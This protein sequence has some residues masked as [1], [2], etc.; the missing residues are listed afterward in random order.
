MADRLGLETVLSPAAMNPYFYPYGPYY[1][2]QQRPRFDPGAEFRDNIFAR[3]YE[4]YPNY[5]LMPQYPAPPPYPYGHYH[6]PGPFFQNQYLVPPQQY[7]APAPAVP[8]PVLRDHAA[9]HYTMPVHQPPSHHI[10]VPEPT[11]VH[12]ID[13][14][15]VPDP[16]QEPGALPESLLWNP[17]ADGNWSR[18]YTK[19]EVDQSKSLMEHWAN[20]SGSGDRR[21]KVDATQ[22]Q[23][24][25]RTRRKCLGIMQCEAEP[26]QCDVITRPQT[27]KDSRLRQLAALVPVKARE[28]FVRKSHQLLDCDTPAMLLK[29]V[30]QLT[31]SFPHTERFF[32]WWMRKEV[33]MMLFP[34]MTTMHPDLWNVMPDSTNA[35]EAMHQRFYL[36][37]KCGGNH[38]ILTG[39][40]H[41]Y[42]FLDHC[43]RQSIATRTGQDIR[44]GP[45]QRWKRKTKI[46][47]LSK[48]QGAIEFSKL[49]AKSRL[50]PAKRY[51]NDGR[52]PVKAKRLLQ[53]KL[54]QRSKK[55]KSNRQDT[56]T[57]SNSGR[58]Q[59]NDVPPSSVVV[60]GAQ[61]YVW[62]DNSCWHDTS[63]QVFCVVLNHDWLVFSQ[64]LH[65]ISDANPRWI[66][67]WIYRW[68]KNV[69]HDAELAPV[70]YFESWRLLYQRCTGSSESS[71]QP[72]AKIFAEPKIDPTLTLFC[73][74]DNLHEF[75]G[76]MQKWFT[77][78]TNV[79]QFKPSHCWHVRQG[80]KLCK[81]TCEECQCY[82][83][84]PVILII[85]MMYDSNDQQPS[86]PWKVPLWLK[87]W[88]SAKGTPLSYELRARI[89]SNTGHFKVRYR[90]S[91]IEEQGL[92]EYDGV[93]HGGRPISLRNATLASHLAGPDSGLKDL[94]KGYYTCTVI[95]QVLGRLSTVHQFH[96]DQ[97]AALKLFHNVE[98]STDTLSVL[99]RLS[100]VD[101]AY[102]ICPDKDRDWLAYPKQSKMID[103]RQVKFKRKSGN[104][105]SSVTKKP[106]IE[107]SDHR[108]PADV[109]DLTSDVEGRSLDSDLE[110]KDWENDS[111]WAGIKSQD[112]QTTDLP[113]FILGYSP[114]RDQ[115]PSD[116]N[117]FGSDKFEMNCRCGVKGDGT[118]LGL[119]ISG[120]EET[121]ICRLFGKSSHLACQAGD[122]NRLGEIDRLRILGRDGD[123]TS[124]FSCH[125]CHSTTRSSRP[126]HAKRKTKLPLRDRLYPGKGVLARNG[127]FSYP[128]RL[129]Q[130]FEDTD[131][132]ELVWWWGCEFHRTSTFGSPGGRSRVSTKCIVDEL[133]GDL[134]G[135][136][137]IRLGK[138]T[139]AYHVPVLENL[140]LDLGDF[141]EE[142]EAALRPHHRL[143]EDLV[144]RL[145][146]IPYNPDI[147]VIAWQAGQFSL[148]S[149]IGAGASQLSA[150]FVGGMSLADLSGITNWIRTQ[151]GGSYASENV[152]SSPGSLA[153]AHARTL[154][155]AH[156][157]RQVYLAADLASDRTPAQVTNVDVDREALSNLEAAM[158]ED[159]NEAGRAG[160]SQWGLD[161]GYHQDYWNPYY[162][163]LPEWSYDDHDRV[164]VDQDFEQGENYRFDSDCN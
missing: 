36:S 23:Q 11:T 58:S 87:A 33:A 104:S 98:F 52:P 130:Y 76:S 21:G 62:G 45:G 160:N 103:Y 30:K 6:P 31:D 90:G 121:V 110:T 25:R 4:A 63:M 74:G 32:N 141:T 159:S 136:R 9:A 86:S 40:E 39:F 15:P 117:D 13:P 149:A 12:P 69:K 3:P 100:L 105:G 156:R 107:S 5:P 131:E 93:L 22:W 20:E 17:W 114:S 48:R 49:K 70:A 106:K 108:E 10:P 97:I 144:L 18:N 112:S 80:K 140:L 46:T 163:L 43:R 82:V 67:T 37:C 138:F 143:L 19:P 102:E 157:N 96:R 91:T 83:S 1:R 54:Q 89:L 123:L 154:L 95:Y 133:W 142:I 126:Q 50:K 61:S 41:I 26:E 34:T 73:Y 162:D 132:W 153:H 64:D 14:R 16:I 71:R 124:L 8:D 28:H 94:P 55:R 99:P 51:Q 135:R 24:G 44:Y 68:R 115:S 57:S 59:L 84:L 2:P 56:D 60:Y 139:H 155:D 128:V 129:I 38:D 81:G 113:A 7:R 152:W 79:K 161:A 88:T 109:V 65:N 118:R 77:S 148:E 92:F 66:E 75:Q 27:T 42:K 119:G 111:E 53:A 35:G 78:K 29:D 158:F 150:L 125:L 85:E 151:I 134:S 120:A 47:G 127:T 72:H 145:D 146:T 116:P 101:P 164:E 137:N 147:P 122:K